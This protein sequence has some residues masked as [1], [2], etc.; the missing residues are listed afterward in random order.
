[1]KT[2]ICMAI[3]MFG[4]AESA[5]QTIQIIPPGATP[6]TETKLLDDSDLLVTTRGYVIKKDEEKDPI[7]VGSW[8]SSVGKVI[9]TETNYNAKGALHGQQRTFY[10]SGKLMTQVS[11]LD[12]RRHGISEFYSPEGVL[13]ARGTFDNDNLDGESCKFD[14]KGKL[15]ERKM[16][17][18]GV[19]EAGK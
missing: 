1:M 15:I 17:K 11:Y 16:Y 10:P 2:L 3:T 5:D 14:Q 9:I 4:G 12:G 8:V 6:V 18:N 19:A 7:R 13:L